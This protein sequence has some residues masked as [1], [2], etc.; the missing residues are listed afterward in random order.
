MLFAAQSGCPWVAPHTSHYSAALLPIQLKR[1][2]SHRGTNFL[3][4]FLSNTMFLK[5]FSCL[6][7]YVRKRFLL[8]TAYSLLK[9]MFPL[10]LISCESITFRWWRVGN[11]LLKSDNTLNSSCTYWWCYGI[12]LFINGGKNFATLC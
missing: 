3:S 8:L 10:L 12:S 7:F 2:T 1:S 11:W 5:H 9:S 4:F 6:V